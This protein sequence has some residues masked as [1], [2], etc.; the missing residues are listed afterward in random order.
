MG[1]SVKEIVHCGIYKGPI[2]Y[3]KGLY[4]P[5]ELCIQSGTKFTQQILPFS[6]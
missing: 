2:H 6:P 1:L 4:N 3:P 5:D